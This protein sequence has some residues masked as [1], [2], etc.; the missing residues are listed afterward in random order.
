VEPAVVLIVDDDPA[1]RESLSA[2]LEAAGFATRA[3]D[4]A[5]AFFE[6]CKEVT[7]GCG[8][9]DVGLPDM[10]GLVLQELL[11]K[12][13]IRLPLIV[14][15]GHADVP[16]AVKAMQ[17]G[18][19][20]F[21][22]KPYSEDALIASVERA[23]AASRNASQRADGGSDSARER[24]ARL[25]GRERDVLALLIEGQPNKIIAYNLGISPRTVELHRARVM[26]KAEVS[27]LPELVRL[28]IA[29]G[30]GPGGSL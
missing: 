13:G 26:S 18:A 6:A 30:V 11:N 19:M 23:I 12:E 9:V 2:L 25:T 17:A 16:M 7:T 20:D 24:L 14:V 1:I 15:T 3:T 8:I 27:S 22:E 21:L 29:A 5:L 4:T 10:S 28:A